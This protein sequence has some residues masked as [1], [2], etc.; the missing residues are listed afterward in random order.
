MLRSMQ[1]SKGCGNCTCSDKNEQGDL[2]YALGPVLIRSHFSKE[3][4][5]ALPLSIL[6]QPFRTLEHGPTVHTEMSVVEHHTRIAYQ[7]LGAD[8]S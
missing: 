2:Y 1:L 7:E 5:S 6:I 3:S 4:R 8:V